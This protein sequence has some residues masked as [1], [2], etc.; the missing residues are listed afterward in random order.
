M[1]LDENFYTSS[2]VN[3]LKDPGVSIFVCARKIV[4]KG[5]LHFVKKFDLAPEKESYTQ[6]RYSLNRA[7]DNSFVNKVPPC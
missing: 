4:K 2:L 1:K 3:A 5:D 6:T 7:H